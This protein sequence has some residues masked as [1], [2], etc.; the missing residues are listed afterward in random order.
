M[1]RA[2]NTNVVISEGAPAREAVLRRVSGGRGC[3]AAASGPAP[4]QRA[5]SDRDTG[6]SSGRNDGRN[7]GLDPDAELVERV[8]QR[9]A[10]AV[11]TLI[12]RKLPRLLRLATR[13]LGDRMEAE[14]VAQ[15]AFERIWTHAPRWKA[16]EAKFDTWLHRVALNLC[17][18]RLRAHRE[19]PVDDAP[20]VADHAATPAEHAERQSRDAQIRA[21]L[22]SLPARQREALVL[23]YYQELSNIE[24]AALMGISVDALESLLARARRNLRAL[25]VER[26]EGK[27]AS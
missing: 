23:N 7:G 10:A 20:D 8:G 9:D 18:D 21:A 11:R 4:E 17:Y 24:A 26:G 14:D 6:H 2:V 25:L 5:L 15:E 1:D 12:A 3:R 22:S 13:M 19:T 27:E 16:G